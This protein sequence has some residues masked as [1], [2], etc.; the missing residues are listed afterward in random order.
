[1]D[2]A[3]IITEKPS[4]ARDI[5][6]ALGGFSGSS[7]QGYWESSHSVCTFAVGHLLELLSPEDI[8]PNYRQWSLH[9]LPILP[10][11]FSLKPIQ[12]HQERLAI[13]R[14]LAQRADITRLIN[15]CDAAREGEL[16][17]REI[18]AYLGLR[19]PIERVWLQ[20]MTHEAIRASFAR[21]KPGE[22]LR[23]LAEAAAC[24]AK[25]DWLI[26]MNATRAFSKRFARPGDAGAWSVGRVQTPTLALLVERELTILA[27]YPKPYFQIKAQ[28]YAEDHRYEGLWFDPCFK[29]PASGTPDLGQ[30]DDRILDQAAARAILDALQPGAPADAKETRDT[31]QRQAPAPFDLTAL[32]KHMATRFKWTSKRTLESAQRCYETHKVITYPRT[33]SQCLPS[34]YEP[35]VMRVFDRLAAGGVLTQAIDNLKQSGLQNRE[36][37]FNDAGVTDHFAIVPTGKLNALA[38]DDAKLFEAVSERFVAAFHG[39]AVYSRVRRVTRVERLHFRT[40]PIETLVTPGWMAVTGIPKQNTQSLPRLTSEKVRVCGGKLH[41]EQ[42]KPPPRISEAGLLSLMEHA[43]RQVGDENLRAALI[44]AEGLGTPATRADIIQNLKAKGYVEPDLR[45][46]FKGIYLIET[47]RQIGVARLTSAELTG[48]LELELGEV[49]RGA[50]PAATFMDEIAH[51]VT[52]VVNAAK[53]FDFTKIYADQ[54]GLGPCPQCREGEVA[55]QANQYSC[56]RACGFNLPKELLGRYVDRATV[57]RLVHAG[58]TGVIDGLG[59]KGRPTALALRGGQLLLQTMDAGGKLLEVEPPKKQFD[60]PRSTNHPSFADCSVHGKD[61]R[62]IETRGSWMCTTRLQQLRAWVADP[63][64]AFLPKTVCGRT[65]TPDEA[66]AF[67]ENGVTAELAGFQYRAGRRFDARIVMRPGGAWAFDFGSQKR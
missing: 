18:V 2:K 28:F 30:R 32:Q 20:S 63:I 56:S 46:T 64:G 41:A 35:E 66:K 57:T 55:E 5:T 15:A 67:L 38:G 42:T 9:H 50:R 45:P 25:S 12:E 19:L 8:Y 49:E 29:K 43:G 16:I 51:Y 17:F 27:H 60:P 58:E 6:A 23:G 36:R 52:D 11:S 13:I 22:Q 37:I 21:L 65:L 40:G 39:P 47:L 24:R 59:G 14:R 34:D 44:Q 3:L 4:V 26:G 62:V 31:S 1:M 53:A 10:S 54:K 33:G 7:Q 61:C 48:R